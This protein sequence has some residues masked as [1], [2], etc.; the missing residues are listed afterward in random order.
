MK[1]TLILDASDTPTNDGLDVRSLISYDVAGLPRGEHAKMA[2]F[3]HAW[4]YL[5]WNDEWHGN[6]TGKYPTIES[7]LNALR[8][9]LLMLAQ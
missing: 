9:E 7:A 1:L 4:R 3:K 6:W 5:R 2:Y 8:E